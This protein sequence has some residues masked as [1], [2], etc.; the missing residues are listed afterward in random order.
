MTELH[1]LL[2]TESEAGLLG[3][4]PGLYRAAQTSRAFDG[5][6]LTATFSV[7]GDGGEYLGEIERRYRGGQE[8]P[9]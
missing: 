5:D 8:R 2:L 7:I 4:S 9:R 3:V 6:R 1:G